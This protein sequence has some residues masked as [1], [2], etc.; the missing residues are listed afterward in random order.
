LTLRMHPLRYLLFL[1]RIGKILLCAPSEIRL[2]EGIICQ[3][4]PAEE[5]CAIR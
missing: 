3:T 2:P 5:H 4:L 1:V